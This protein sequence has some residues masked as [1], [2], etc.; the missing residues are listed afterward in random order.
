VPTTVQQHDTACT[1]QH[2][3]QQDT[4]CQPQ[5]TDH[6]PQYNSTQPAHHSAAT[7][8]CLHTGTT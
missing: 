4:A 6:V 8:L 7:G 3:Q 5:Y 1:P 2:I